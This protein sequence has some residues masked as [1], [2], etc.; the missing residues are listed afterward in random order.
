[1]G[2]YK[3]PRQKILKLHRGLKKA[4]SSVLIHR[5]TGKV[6]LA[7]FLCKRRVP[8]YSSPRCRCR[9]GDGTPAHLLLE[10]RLQA[11]RGG[12]MLEGLPRRSFQDLVSTPGLAAASTTIWVIQSGEFPQFDLVSTLLYGAEADEA[13]VQQPHSREGGGEGRSGLRVRDCPGLKTSEC[14]VQRECPA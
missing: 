9:G 7:R 13:R 6:G 8:G 14:N 10:C 12:A 4:E 2:D 1:M 5:R 11:Q 3:G